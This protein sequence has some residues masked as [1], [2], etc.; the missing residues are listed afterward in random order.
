MLASL[1]RAS[2]GSSAC[3][4][5]LL[6]MWVVF[7]NLVMSRIICVICSISCLF[8]STLNSGYQS[9]SGGALQG[10]P[11]PSCSSFVT[12]HQVWLA[13]EIF[14]LHIGLLHSAYRGEVEPISLDISY[15]F[16]L[17]IRWLNINECPINFILI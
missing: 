6:R 4:M 11:L 15:N 5:Q 9:G 1:W 12:P 8:H 14:V 17:P 10:M 7:E 13:T 16:L 2:A 3:C